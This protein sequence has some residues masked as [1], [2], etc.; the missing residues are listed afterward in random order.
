M[1]DNG[2]PY[3]IGI[4]G[5]SSSGK[6]SFLNQLVSLMPEDSVSVIS[7]D[8]YYFP[9]DQQLCQLIC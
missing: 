5:G 3:I 6:T 1:S 4:A 2:K 8:N 7:Q 9:K